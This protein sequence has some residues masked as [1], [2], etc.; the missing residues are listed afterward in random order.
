MNKIY[1]N[2]NLIKFLE[3]SYFLKFLFVAFIG[4]HIPLISIIIFILNNDDLNKPS[5]ILASILFTLLAT[6]LTLIILNKLLEPLII[7]KKAL[8]Q[9]LRF[10]TIPVL[11]ENY[12]DEAGVL[13]NLI[14][15]SVHSI[16]NL[17]K[18]KE[19]ISAL[20]SHNLRTPFNQI[21]GLC[22]VL[23]TDDPSNQEVIKNINL[24][25]DYQLKN[26]S[27]LLSNINNQLN[28]KSTIITS[29]SIKNLIKDETAM[30]LTDLAKK[31]INIKT[32]FPEEDI[33]I[34]TDKSKLTLVLQ[35]LLTNALK[36]SFPGK[37]IYIAFKKMDE[38]VHISIKDEGIGFPADYENEIFIANS[39]LGRIGTAGEPSNGI[40]LNLS[41]KTMQVLGGDLIAKS[42]GENKGAEFT[43][44]I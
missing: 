12:K 43:I 15:E 4:I 36:F 32:T 31:Q 24:V 1:N 19:E 7:A 30:F 44:I 5:I 3:K 9:Y 17:I 23:D 42:D 34:N 10:R 13:M 38:K 16:D 39:K 41:K 21:K 28:E 14:K 37:T 6:A 26:V 27:E 40:G 35:N 29:F 22:E 33:V 20:L 8:E 11:P 18:E 2:L 25:C